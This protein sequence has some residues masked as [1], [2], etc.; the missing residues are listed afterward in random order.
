MIF[1]GNI[2]GRDLF[3][4]KGMYVTDGY[5]GNVALK[6]MEGTAGYLLGRV[7][8][9]ATGNAR[10]KLGGLLLRPA[11][12]GVKQA[13]DPD[14]HGGSYLLGLRGLLIICHGAST[15]RAIANALSFG[16]KAVRN[17]VL[18][19]LESEL[20]RIMPDGGAGQASP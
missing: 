1:E 4:G 20:G 15:S 5:T 3:S 12:R 13:L 9:A 14:A 10:S 17:G 18:A 6:L 7:R 19:R 11:L 8:E 2:E 16:A